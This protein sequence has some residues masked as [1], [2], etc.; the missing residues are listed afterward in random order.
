VSRSFIDLD[1]TA[2]P[3][4]LDP[5]FPLA[6]REIVAL[7]ET[8]L[9]ALGLSAAHLSLTLADDSGIALLNARHLGC[10]GPTNILSFPEGPPARPGE[11]REL[12]ALF[13]SVETL[14]REVF[15]Y[16][17]EPCIHLARLLAHGILHLAG[18]DH[19]PE[20]DALTDMAV[21][22]AESIHG[23][24]GCGGGACGC[25]CDSDW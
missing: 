2:P 11:P 12:G 5:C 13:L 14:A 25:S 7:M 4:V 19:G 22:V 9:A 3:A 21:A 17:Q 20:M 24:G 15:L 8:L 16:G 1:I 23:S 10:Q 18:H 6:R